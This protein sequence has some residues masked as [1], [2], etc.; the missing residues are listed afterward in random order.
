M[1]PTRK[2]FTPLLGSNW[3]E[4]LKLDTGKLISYNTLKKTLGMA[5][6]PATCQEK[7]KKQ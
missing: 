3:L 1:I 7:S 4:A 2:D 6:I 5:K